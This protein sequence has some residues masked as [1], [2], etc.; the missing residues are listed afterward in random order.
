[1]LAWGSDVSMLNSYFLY[2]MHHGSE[3]PHS[4][5]FSCWWDACC[6]N[7]KLVQNV[8]FFFWGGM[9]YPY[10]AKHYMVVW[11]CLSCVENIFHYTH[12]WS[13]FEDKLSY[14][15]V[16]QRYP[17]YIILHGSNRPILSPCECQC[18]CLGGKTVVNLVLL[19]TVNTVALGHHLLYHSSQQ[20]K[21]LDFT[22]A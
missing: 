17:L 18:F 19:W 5:C 12:L 22:V 10:N 7:G 14:Y 20:R 1:M 9:L 4:Q 16:A 11:C 6:Q 13:P 21:V 15:T 3:W 8:V 2:K